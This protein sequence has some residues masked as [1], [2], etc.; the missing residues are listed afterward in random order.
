MRECAKFRRPHT[1]ESFQRQSDSLKAY[2]TEHE[3]PFKGKQHTEE[4]KLKNRLKHVGKIAVNNG[5]ISKMISSDE[6][7][8]YISAGWSRG[9]GDTRGQNKV[10]LSGA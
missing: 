8:S 5:D 7:E 1:E 10:N 9:Y 4:A 6:L 2:Y 3:N